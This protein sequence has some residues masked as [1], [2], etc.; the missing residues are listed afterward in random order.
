MKTR[1]I[2]VMK[3]VWLA[4]V[5]VLALL[6]GVGIAG[7]GPPLHQ[8]LIEA[9]RRG[10]LESVKT[11]LGMGAN[12]NAEDDRGMTALMAACG[13][14]HVEVAQLLIDGDADV[15][16]RDSAGETALMYAASRGLFEVVK[17]LV[18][19]GAALRQKGHERDGETALE[20]AWKNG[21]A[22]TVEFLKERTHVARA[23]N[24]MPWRG[25][26]ISS[27]PRAIGVRVLG[28]TGEVVMFR[29][30]DRHRRYP[31]GATIEAWRRCPGSKCN[32]GISVIDSQE[33]GD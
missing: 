22:K 16:A 4:M 30:K 12:V 1:R 31:V 6:P 21:D 14:G 8:Q 15:N 18:E 5:L 13:Q 32:Y 2:P 3:K 26:V 28:A 33:A 24:T 29:W 10:N 7:P 23:T 19:N 9:A 27:T 20:M 17:L 25:V 11:L